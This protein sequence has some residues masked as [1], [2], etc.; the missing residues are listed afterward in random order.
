MPSAL[1]MCELQEAFRE[2]R[3]EVMHPDCI[4]V[5]IQQGGEMLERQCADGAQP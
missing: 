1:G 4:R 3:I 5:T 2:Q